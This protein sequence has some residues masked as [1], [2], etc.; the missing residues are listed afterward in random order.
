MHAFAEGLAQQQQELLEAQGKIEAAAEALG[1]VPL[2]TLP[3]TQQEDAQQQEQQPAGPART[4]PRSGDGST[5]PHTPRR[6]RS[7]GSVASLP[8][9]SGSRPT[10]P[11]GAADTRFSTA[12]A[13]DSGARSSLSSPEI[14][15]SGM[16]VSATPAATAG[17]RGGR[18]SEEEGGGCRS[19][20]SAGRRRSAEA[21]KKQ[22][23]EPLKVVNVWFHVVDSGVGMSPANLRVL[24]M[25]FSQP[26]RPPS[27]PPA[28]CSTASSR[29]SVTA[30]CICWWYHQ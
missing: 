22:G 11:P 25:P 16:S 19:R 23:E 29:R 2:P 17:G 10:T 5:T 24:F 14:V 13:G 15:L 12:T 21:K 1:A 20:D 3:P 8:G 28:C 18:G 9:D 26:V 4:G 27:K 30:D 7:T 6:A